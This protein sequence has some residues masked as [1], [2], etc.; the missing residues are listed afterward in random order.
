MHGRD[1]LHSLW[2]ALFDEDDGVEMPAEEFHRAEAGDDYGWP[3]TFFDPRTDRRLLAPEYGGDGKR[4][5]DT[6]AYPEPLYAFPAHW[7]PN[8]MVFYE[9]AQFPARFR[10]GAFIAWHGSWNRAPQPQEGYRVTFLPLAGGTPSGEAETFL[11]GFKGRDKVAQPGEARFRPT[12]LAVAGDGSLY[13]ADSLKGR[14]WR[15]T[16]DPGQAD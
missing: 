6:G 8:D 10:G 3:Y 12:A 14:V 11:D 7:A 1:Q 5:P 13:V 4:G 15:V 9:G 2:P 16:Y